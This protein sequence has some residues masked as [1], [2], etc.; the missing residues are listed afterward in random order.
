[1]SELPDFRQKFL[2]ELLAVE[3]YVGQNDARRGRI[4]TQAVFDFA[5]DIVGAMPEAFPAYTHPLLPQVPLRR[6]LFQRE[7]ALLYRV[8]NQRVIFVFFYH[9]R[10]DIS[11]QQLE[12]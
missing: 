2:N 6:A 7:Y 10:R 11:Q 5:C 9:T 3:Q 12:L 8:L 1:M 4:F